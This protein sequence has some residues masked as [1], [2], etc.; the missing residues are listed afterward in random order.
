M[1]IGQNPAKAIY[2]VA[3]PQK[4]T[5]ALIT[6][7]PFLGGYY[8]HSLDVLKVCLDSL[9]ANTRAP[10]D[11]LI[12]DNASCPE[13]RAYLL[14]EHETGRIRYL[15]LSEKNVGK[16]GA[17]N[18]I[19]G[20]AP[21]EYVAYADSDVY[22]Y[23][24]WLSALLRIAETFPNVGMVTGLPLLTRPEYS[25][26][27]LEWAERSAEVQVE[28]GQL[29]PWMDFWRHTAPLGNSEAKARAFYAENPAVRLT[30]NGVRAYAG[31]GH[32]QFLAPKAALQ[33]ALPLPTD[34]P[35]GNVRSLDVAINAG[36]YLR[37]ST[38][39]W[40]VQHLGN[41]LEGWEGDA[42]PSKGA[43]LQGRHIPRKGGLWGLP[44]VRRVLS[45]LHSKTFDLLYR[46][47]K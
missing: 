2:E 7:I 33:A 15:T 8:A 40:W 6:Y 22:F 4:V 46:A 26:A 21:G 19:F 45:W 17:W 42:A 38:P 25:T 47:G 37:L 36:G 10:Y 20:A 11:L 39:E 18:F 30:Y 24:G 41:T 5:V 13:V 32:F 12:F 23:P 29:I 9:A 43:V 27:T 16:A 35:M 1:R 28:R 34:R 3:Q 31:A 44:P 14:A